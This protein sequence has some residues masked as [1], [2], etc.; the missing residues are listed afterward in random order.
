M[1]ESAKHDGD[2]LAGVSTG[3]VIPGNTGRDGV[4]G[5][6][7]RLDSDGGRRGAVILRVGADAVV[8]V[9]NNGASATIILQHGIPLEQFLQGDPAVRAKLVPCVAL[10]YV[11][12]SDCS[13]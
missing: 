4:S 10:G 7:R 8:V 2:K 5:R 9:R 11:N 1:G 6:G 3:G 13:P 12:V